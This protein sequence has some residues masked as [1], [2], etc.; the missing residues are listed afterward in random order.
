MGATF[1]LITCIASTR[2]TITDGRERETKSFL[3]MVKAV[4][5]MAAPSML[6]NDPNSLM[7]QRPNVLT[8][9]DEISSSVPTCAGFRDGIPTTI[10][11]HRLSISL[12]HIK[13]TP[14]YNLKYL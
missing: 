9:E 8:I 7:P 12:H 10:I 4:T 6:G 2:S 11:G 3:T 14:P 1:I 13:N 5:K